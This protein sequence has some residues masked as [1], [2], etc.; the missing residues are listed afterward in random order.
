MR[1]ALNLKDPGR[2]TQVIPSSVQYF[3]L[4]ISGLWSLGG[5]VDCSYLLFQVIGTLL[6]L[7]LILRGILSI[8][9]PP[10]DTPTFTL[11]PGLP[12]G[13]P[14]RTDRLPRGFY[15][16][17]RRIRQYNLYQRVL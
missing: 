6:S 1:I 17:R 10:D 3:I 5:P 8:D 2:D 14:R 15:K 4:F 12:R 9:R 16:K 13:T 11:P 7:F